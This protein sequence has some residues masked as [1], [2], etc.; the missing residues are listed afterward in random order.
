MSITFAWPKR[1]KV[2]LDRIDRHNCVN[3]NDVFELKNC[4]CFALQIRAIIIQSSRA[5]FAQTNCKDQSIHDKGK[6][7]VRTRTQLILSTNTDDTNNIL[8]Y[9][10]Y[11]YKISLRQVIFNAVFS[12]NNWPRLRQNRGIIY[13]TLYSNTRQINENA[14]SIQCRTTQ[15]SS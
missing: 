7:N 3:T 11:T 8:T 2:D 10:D 13:N 15:R 6:L 12:I 14:T 4:V 9:T 5:S 1:V